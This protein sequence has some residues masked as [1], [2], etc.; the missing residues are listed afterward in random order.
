MNTLTF[1]ILRVLADGHFH[2]GEALAGRFGVTR[3]TVWNALKSLEKL[4]IELFSVKGKGYRLPNPPQFFDEALIREALG[5]EAV[6]FQLD[7]HD[8]LDSTNTRVMQAGA[9]GAASGLCVAALHQTQGRGR[10]GRIWHAGLGASLTFSVLWRFDCGA[11]GLS[12]LSLAVGV[13]LMRALKALGAEEIALKWPNDL[14]YHFHK[15]AGILIELQGD[16]DGASAAV[17]GIGLNLDLPDALRD[18]ID[19]PVTDLKNV[20]PDVVNINLL[21]GT[22]L[23]HLS[24]VLIV[25]QQSGFEALRDEWQGHHAYQA[26]PVNMRMPDGR[27]DTGVVFGVARDGAL[28]VETAQGIQ[29]FSVGEISLRP[30]TRSQT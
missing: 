1:P 14:L 19:Q 25:F 18:H 16:I 21:L 5:Q 6:H 9:Q 17:I 8:V 26:K 3:A 20:L 7:L 13:A 29:R 2:S 30:A 24:Q 12:G 23:K 4:G 27:V 11:S 22:L 10:R 28:Q 15:L